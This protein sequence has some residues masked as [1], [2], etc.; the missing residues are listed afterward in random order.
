[1][2]PRALA[3][4]VFALL[5]LATIAAFFVTQR[6]KSGQPVVRRLA[7][8][9]FFSPNGDH[10][11]DRARISFDLP[12][13][14]RV[15]VDVVDRDGDRVRRL[16]DGRSLARG[17]HALSW[18][19]R[20]DDGTVPPDGTYYVRVTLRRQGRAATGVRGI[21]LV[22]EPPRPHLVS[23]SPS[24]LPGGRPAAVTI[25]FSGP[26]V[27]PPQYGIWRTDAR[28]VRRVALLSGDRQTHSVT[29]DATIGGR[30]APR[31]TYAVSVTVQNRALIAGSAPERVP[32]AR[33]G[34]R[35]RTG[36]TI[37]GATA[38]PPLEPVRAGAVTSFD[39]YGGAAR[40]AWRL[41]LTG[42]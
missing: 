18:D 35:P 39:V 7:L 1:M 17:D 24:W 28:P 9:R 21:A 36:L 25:R 40:V 3:T 8:Q 34:A 15:T 29:W 20:A 38:A 14:D 13:G 32:P 22:T 6:L 19:G 42:R 31:G 11:Q 23:V 26:S 12:R 33:A 30:P 16:V 41:V 2:R 37:G 5:V 4:W 10:R 27:V